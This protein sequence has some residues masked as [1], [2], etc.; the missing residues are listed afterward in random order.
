MV[1][2][3][4]EDMKA[5][6]KR[7]LKPARRI[8]ATTDIWSSKQYRDSYLGE[9]FICDAWDC[10][11][12]WLCFLGV[13]VSFACPTDKVLKSL[14]IGKYSSPS[15]FFYNSFFPACSPFNSS[16]TGS[17]I[18]DKMMEVL[19]SYNIEDKVDHFLTDSAANMIKGEDF[20]FC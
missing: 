10:I 7:S 12:K 9:T 19:K 15:Y 17:N 1:A 18:A 13:T 20:R 11:D 16:H 14:K 4:G 8:S 3:I 2:S 5:K 6:L